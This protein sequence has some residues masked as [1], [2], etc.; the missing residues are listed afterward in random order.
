MVSGFDQ[1]NAVDHGSTSG[2][3]STPQHGRDDRAAAVEGGRQDHGRH[4]AP[5]PYSEVFAVGI[6]I[7]YISHSERREC[8]DRSFKPNHIEARSVAGSIF[9]PRV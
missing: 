2:S 6:V 8:R 7:N 3:N 4:N 5:P 1:G 9:E